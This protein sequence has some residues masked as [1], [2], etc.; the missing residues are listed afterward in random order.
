MTSELDRAYLKPSRAIGLTRLYDAPHPLAVLIVTYKSHDLLEKCLA[1]VAEHL[2]ELPVYVYE[3]S[4]DGYPGRE[5]L[6]ARHPDVHWV[7]GSVNVGFAAAVNALVEHTPPDADLLL[8]NPD[9]RLLGP[10]TRTRQLI[11][12]PGVAAVAPLMW[13][14]A[15]AG[16][17][18]WDVATRRR[19]LLRALVAASG[20]SDR[21]RG[22]RFSLLYGQQPDESQGI[23]GYLCG[24]CMAINRDAWDA[25]GGFDEE[26]FL[27]GEETDWQNRARDAKWRI[28]LADEPGAEHGGESDVSHGPDYVAAERGRIYDLLRANTALLL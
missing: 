18:P 25:I 10:L 5:E 1:Q 20:Y 9:A 23:D 21:L 22:N 27:Y 4:G 2:P 17:A 16:P 8:L 26:F 7:M 3:N 19:T 14:T 24:A 15:G 6:A 28:L 11:R 13:D 12:R